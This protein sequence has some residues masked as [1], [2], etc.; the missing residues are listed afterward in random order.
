VL[1]KGTTVRDII[2]T[3]RLSAAKTPFIVVTEERRYGILLQCRHRG[4][5]VWDVVAARL[6]AAK[7]PFIV[8]TEE[9]RY[10]ILL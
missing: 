7:T 1:P 8:V 5:M 6:S 10:G 4:T 9:R 2:V 3:A